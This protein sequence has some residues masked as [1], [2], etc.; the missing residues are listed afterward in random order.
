MIVLLAI[1]SI[2]GI[3]YDRSLDDDFMA[4]S[5]L[6]GN[7]FDVTYD[8]TGFAPFNNSILRD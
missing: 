5:V 1:C 2:L 8:Y 6:S 4:Y 3:Y 7:G